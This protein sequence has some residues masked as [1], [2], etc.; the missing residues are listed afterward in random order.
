MGRRLLPLA[1]ALGL[2]WLLLPRSAAVRRALRILAL[3]DPQSP[4]WWMLLTLGLVLVPLGVVA[5]VQA[6]PRLLQRTDRRGYLFL[7]ASEATRAWL[8][9]SLAALL[10]VAAA[11]AAAAPVPTAEGPASFEGWEAAAA[12]QIQRAARAAAPPSVDAIA[13]VLLGYAVPLIGLAVPARDA[14]RRREEPLLHVARAT[15]LLALAVLPLWAFLRLDVPCGPESAAAACVDLVAA[16]APALLGLASLWGLGSWP[17]LPVALAGQAVGVAMATGA[18]SRI[19]IAS[20]A[21]L[22]ILAATMH[23]GQ[24]GPG[25]AASGSLAG[26][27]AAWATRRRS[28]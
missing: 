20:L 11:L 21:A 17:Q 10:I 28:P 7:A 6:T 19:A 9:L 1:Y 18:G 26:L 2:I 14:W 12:S 24:A 27:A 16:R 13:L 8:L 23:L 4:A 15:L 25:A 3:Q 5:L 22:A